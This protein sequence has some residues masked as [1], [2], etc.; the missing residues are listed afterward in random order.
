MSVVVSVEDVGPC[1]KQ[2]TVEV[3]APAVEAETERVAR[4]LSRR[5]KV[6]GFRKGKVPLQIVQQRFRQ[7][8]EREVVDRLVPRYWHQAEA[9]SDLDPMTPPKVEQVDLQQGAPLTFVATVET[10]PEVEL[11]NIH[12]FDLPDMDVEPSEEEIG[13]ALESIRRDTADRVPVDRPASRG[14]LVSLE[15]EEMA[16]EGAP[17]AESQRI[18][19]E[20]GDSNVWEELSL[21][22][23]GLAPEQ[24]A[25]F[26]RRD[27][28]GGAETADQDRSFRIRVLTVKEAELPPLDDDLAKRFG[29]FESLDELRTD[30]GE[31]LRTEKMAER[32]VKRERAMLEQLAERH[33][34]R[35][36]EGVVE[37]EIRQLLQEYAESMSQRGVDVETAEL[38]WEGLAQELRPQAER[39]TLVRFLLDAVAKAEGISVSEEEF[40]SRLAV[41]AR[42]Q[43]QTTVAVRRTLD[44]AGRLGAL[45]AQMQ[46]EK[47][48]RH[49]LDEDDRT[50]AEQDSER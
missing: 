31:R 42:A 5:V 46:R 3:P 30:I 9:E 45:R 11:G 49:L 22:V 12:D 2:L 32:R 26:V 7:D 25:E 37:G 4:D 47:T 48:I 35:L 21:A 34:V 14:D 36:P 10:R 27:A 15:V 6:P 44:E 23:T 28:G 24:E 41:I 19:V 20:V 50:I 43:R 17:S 39:R 18:E 40:E 16:T 1:R 33:P 29:D 38:D 13:E 8:I